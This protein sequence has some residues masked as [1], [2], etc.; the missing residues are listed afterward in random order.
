MW[1]TKNEGAGIKKPSNPIPLFEIS[2]QA[3]NGESHYAE[4]N[5]KTGDAVGKGQVS[6]IHPVNPGD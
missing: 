2:N 6:E 1:S 5:P 4:Q 3:E